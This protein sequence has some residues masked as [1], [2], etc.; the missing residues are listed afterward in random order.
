MRLTRNAMLA[1]LEG[2]ESRWKRFQIATDEVLRETDYG[3]DVTVLGRKKTAE[4]IYRACAHY[5]SD[6]DDMTE[7]AQ[8]IWEATEDGNILIC[9]SSH[10][11]NLEE[12]MFDTSACELSTQSLFYFIARKS[13]WHLTSVGGLE[14][15]LSVGRSFD[16]HFCLV[17]DPSAPKLKQLNEKMFQGLAHGFTLGPSLSVFKWNGEETVHMERLINLVRDTTRTHEE[18]E[19]LTNQMCTLRDE[20]RVRQ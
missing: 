18:L 10:V 15:A 17:R 13:G 19:S 2:H 20:L 3:Y 9:A 5:R 16:H 6:D 7:I 4:A 14:G 1:Y 11:Q 12:N 8:L